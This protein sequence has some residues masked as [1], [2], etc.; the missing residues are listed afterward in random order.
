MSN[1]HSI[2]KVNEITAGVVRGGEAHV[3]Y[4]RL[5]YQVL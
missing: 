3:Y 5:V 4:S 1:I 2:L